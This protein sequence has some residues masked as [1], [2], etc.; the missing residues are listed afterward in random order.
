MRSLQVQSTSYNATNDDE[1]YDES[2]TNS[3]NNN[4][5]QIT[6]PSSPYST[7][8]TNNLTLGSNSDRLPRSKSVNSAMDREKRFHRSLAGVKNLVYA[9]GAG[10][11]TGNGNGVVDSDDGGN[12][13]DDS[14]VDRITSLERQLKKALFANEVLENELQKWQKKYH[15]TSTSTDHYIRQE[16]LSTMTIQELREQV[17]NLNKRL[18]KQGKS[19]ME[20]ERQNRELQERMLGFVEERKALI[21]K[22]DRLNLVLGGLKGR[23]GEEQANNDRLNKLLEEETSRRKVAEQRDEA[24]VAMVRTMEDHLR[25]ERSLKEAAEEKLAFEV[26]MRK[27]EAINNV[28][29]VKAQYQSIIDELRNEVK[30]LSEENTLLQ[31]LTNPQEPSTNSILPSSS[32]TSSSPT[33]MS[34]PARVSPSGRTLTNPGMFPPRSSSAVDLLEEN[35]LPVDGTLESQLL[36]GRVAIARESE[37]QR[38]RAEN[39]ALVNQLVATLDS[40]TNIR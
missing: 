31:D 28:D 15:T 20:V 13:S 19:L 38:L 10:S 25:Q 26:K 30:T 34:T 27:A 17:I 7:T 21:E 23:V 40:I 16:E 12:G 29:E 32:T 35:K 5:N 37:I 1:D 39:M 6:P 14:Y 33:P 24:L 4:T 36:R 9:Y 3:T 22:E 2:N 11:G 8:N 18:Q